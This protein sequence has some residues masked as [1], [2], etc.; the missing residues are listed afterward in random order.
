MTGGENIMRLN[1]CACVMCRLEIVA[2]FECEAAARLI[3]NLRFTA[4][5]PKR[6]TITNSETRFFVFS[7]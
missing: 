2:I 4:L 5:R 7:E 1:Y 3:F 6:F